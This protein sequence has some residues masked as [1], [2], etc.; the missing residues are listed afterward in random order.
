MSPRPPEPLGAVR[1]DKPLRD[2]RVAWLTLCALAA[3]AC[4]PAG[5]PHVADYRSPASHYVVRLTGRTSAPVSFLREHRLRASIL[6]NGEPYVPARL[7]HFADWMD[8]AFDD[9]SGRP[10][11]VAANILRFPS[12][13]MGARIDPLSDVLTIKNHCRGPIRSIRV[14]STNDLFIGIDLLPGVE[15][16]LQMTPLASTAE[17]ASFFVDAE[18]G[19]PAMPSSA[20]ASFLLRGGREGR[21]RFRVDVRSDRI[22]ITETTGQS[23]PYR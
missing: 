4:E 8:T 10:N 14:E 9:R 16:P 7:I 12:Q 21:Y 20:H 1:W 15:T 22:R 5:D 3:V 18:W 17:V 23:E 11:W 19:P 6:K 2:V 13:W